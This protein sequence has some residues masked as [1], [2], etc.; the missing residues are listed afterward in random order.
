MSDNQKIGKSDDLIILD[1]EAAAFME[2]RTEAQRLQ[3]MPAVIV[4]LI[5][6]LFF[7]FTLLEYFFPAF[8][9]FSEPASWRNV[10]LKQ[11]IHFGVIP[12]F[13][14]AIVLLIYKPA[15]ALI[16]RRKDA[17][18]SMS[19]AFLLGIVSAFAYYV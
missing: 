8:S 13:V 10:A 5:A 9:L 2:E 4:L 11:V 18:L 12:L 14:L 7:A 6:V 3:Y 1:R 16:S 17:P 19:S 15:S